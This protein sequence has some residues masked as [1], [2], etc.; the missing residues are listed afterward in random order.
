LLVLGVNCVVMVLPAWVAG[1]GFA[2]GRRWGWWTRVWARS[3]GGI[4]LGGGAVLLTALGYWWA[5]YL[6]GEQ[7][8]DLAAVGHVVLAAHLPLAALEGGLTAILIAA[9]GRARP[10]LFLP[11]PSP[12]R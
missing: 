6:G 9:L 1:A 3:L 2:L 7:T 4:C 12:G 11:F 10:E 5:L 8:G